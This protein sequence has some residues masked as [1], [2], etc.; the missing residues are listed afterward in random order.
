M[1][2]VFYPSHDCILAQLVDTYCKQYSGRTS[3]NLYTS[4]IKWWASNMY[5]KSLVI[6]LNVAKFVEKE[7]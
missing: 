5:Y 3:L 2:N 6:K 1:L 7:W 4:I